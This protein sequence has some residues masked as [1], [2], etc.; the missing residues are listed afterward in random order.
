M[1]V[2]TVTDPSRPACAM[3]SASRVCSLALSTLWSMPRRS[4]AADSFS[5]F[6]TLTVP[7][8]VGWPAP[9]RS[10]MS[11]TTASNLA[12]SVL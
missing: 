1:F 12:A 5:E 9:M 7:T 10:E 2:A 11:S 3:I 6:S 8:S 4:N